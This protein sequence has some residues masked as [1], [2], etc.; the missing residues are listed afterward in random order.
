[1]TCPLIVKRVTDEKAIKAKGL[2]RMMGLSDWV[3]WLSHFVSFFTIMAVHN[4]LF[5]AIY[6]IGF[7]GQ[8]I[9]QY[10]E[11]MFLKRRY[12]GGYHLRIAKASGFDRQKFEV[13][14]KQFLPE[15][16][17]TLDIGTEMVF[18]LEA[19]KDKSKPKEVVD[20]Q[21]QVFAQLFTKLEDQKQDLKIHSYGVSLTS[22]EEVFI[23]V[24]SDEEEG[25]KEPEVKIKLQQNLRETGYKLCFKQIY[26]LMMKRIHFAKRFI[27][28]F[29]HAKLH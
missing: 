5:T 8:P 13:I 11:P 27:I 14:L 15:A 3:F 24:L 19:G 4:L 9:Y 7:G 26:G 12:G 2:L 22:L 25:K 28:D 23:N 18:S 1:M 21:T 20:S 10:M 16:A 29:R 6:Y 17:T